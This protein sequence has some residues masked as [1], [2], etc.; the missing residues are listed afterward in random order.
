[1]TTKAYI[2]ELFIQGQGWKKVHEIYPHKG[3]VETYEDALKLGL[4]LILE[5]M[6]EKENK[7]YGTSQ[8]DIVGIKITETENQKPEEIP[9]EAKKIK[10]KEHKHK[11]YNRGKAHML[12]K[13]WS[14]PD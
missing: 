4:Y 3:I 14:W 2:V 9:E 1:M 7:T 6:K 5:K 10:W 8:G 11:F 13:T 12:Y